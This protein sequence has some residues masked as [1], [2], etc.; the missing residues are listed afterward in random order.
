MS[1]SSGVE[2]ALASPIEA[3]AP[4]AAMHAKLM[5]ATDS[6]DVQQ[7]KDLVNKQEE[8]SKMMVLVMAKQQA[9]A[10]A[11]N[12][13]PRQGNMDPRLLALASSGS[14][15]ELQTLLNGVHSHGSGNGGTNGNGSLPTRR[16]TSSYGDDTE[17]NES[18]LAGKTAEGDTALHVVA[19]CGEGDNFFTRF[20]DLRH[21]LAQQN[22]NYNNKKKKKKK[23]RRWWC[24]GLSRAEDHA[25]NTYGDGDDFLESA[26]I[27]Y[28]KAKDLLFEQNNEGNTPLHCAARAGKPN[29][30]KCLVDLAL[31]EGGEGKMKELLWKENKHKETVLHEAVRVGNNKIVSLLM[32]K[33]SELA[34]FPQYGGASPLYLAIILKWDLIEATLYEKSARGKLSFSGR[35]GQNALHAAVLRHQAAGIHASFQLCYKLNWFASFVGVQC[36]HSRTPLDKH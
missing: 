7:L 23:K 20:R 22:N 10:S 12:P 6:G 24:C 21:L 17:A 9:A 16:A 27:I 36:I 19:A 28:R 11:E 35:N 29:M 13:N 8:D 2:E 5:V 1:S 33:D 26:R 30:V 15:V 18:I 34:N 14:S 3:S 31:A 32:D 4:V 25:W